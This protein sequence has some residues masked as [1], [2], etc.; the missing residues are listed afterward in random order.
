LTK[1]I[2]VIYN[3]NSLSE[4][5]SLVRE[6]GYEIVGKIYIRRFTS[7]GL[8]S[9]KINEIKGLMNRTEAEAVLFDTPLKPKHLYNIA[10]ELKVEPKDRLQII[11]EIFKLHSPSKEADLQIKLASLQYELTRARERVRLARL[12]EQPALILGPGS[13]EVDVYYNEIKRRIQN[14]KRKLNE[15]RRK[16]ELHRNFRRRRGYKTVSITGY[17]SSGKT[18]LFNSLT[19][20]YMKTGPEPFTT[21]STKFSTIKVGPWDVYLVDTIGFIS[22]LPPFMIKAFYSTL[23]EITMSDL[24]LLIIDVS[25]PYDKVRD[26]L[27]TSFNIIRQLGYN[28]D[29]IIVGNK[30]DLINNPEH[31]DPLSKTFEE[32]SP[33]YIFISALSNL[34]IDR[35]VNVMEKLLGK[36]V[37]IKVKFLYKDNKW[38][39]L[40][41][42]LKSSSHRSYNISFE[43]DGILF[44]GIVDSRIA[45]YIKNKSGSKL[46]V[47]HV[48]GDMDSKT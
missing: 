28:R 34:N 27:E 6:A 37:Y 19:G 9:Y 7:Y 29:V 32:Y 16:R 30:V 4:F 5:I 20:L 35:L 22:D 1:A 47:E 15:E 39:Y 25:E 48:E 45:N 36:G 24:V 18:T 21:I 43:E 2:I 44:E 26:K 3:R 46:I 38:G 11:L 31:L 17:T 8:S 42:I 12:G 13:Y 23:E 33:Y 40:L 41:D 14:I 10:K